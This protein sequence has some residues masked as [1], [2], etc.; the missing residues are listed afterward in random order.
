MIG[1]KVVLPALETER[2]AA[3]VAHQLH[4]F[5]ATHHASID[6]D[7]GEVLL[8]EADHLPAGL[9]LVQH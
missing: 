8:I 5:I 2:M 3:G 6:G 1:L 9:L 7:L 4:I